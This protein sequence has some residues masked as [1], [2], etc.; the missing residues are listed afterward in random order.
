MAGSGS[1]AP[2]LIGLAEVAGVARL[3][4][5]CFQS[6]WKKCNQVGR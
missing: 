3:K 4:R 6:S 5:R 2:D 1:V